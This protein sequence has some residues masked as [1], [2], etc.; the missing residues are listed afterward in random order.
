MAHI[1]N[2]ASLKVLEKI[3]MKFSKEDI[4]DGAPVKIYTLS[5]PAFN[6]FLLNKSNYLR[7]IS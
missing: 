4:I 7:K 5:L 2:I 6:Q 3:G 1:E